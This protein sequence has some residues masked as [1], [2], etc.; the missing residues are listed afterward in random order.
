[1]PTGLV[2]H[3][4]RYVSMLIAINEKGYVMHVLQSTSIIKSYNG[5]KGA[6]EG[7]VG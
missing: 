3:G 1:M 2:Y 7:F 4:M 6:I 5:N